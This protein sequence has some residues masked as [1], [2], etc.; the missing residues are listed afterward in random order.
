I[1]EQFLLGILAQVSLSSRCTDENEAVVAVTTLDAMVKCRENHESLLQAGLIE[2]VEELIHSR[3]DAALVITLKLIC[4]LMERGTPDTRSSVFNVI[5]VMKCV[6]ALAHTKDVSQS[7]IS[8]AQSILAWIAFPEEMRIINDARQRLNDEGDGIKR[9]LLQTGIMQKLSQ[10]LKMITKKLESYSPNDQ[11]LDDNEKKEQDKEDDKQIDDKDDKE[12]SNKQTPLNKRKKRRKKKGKLDDQNR[13]KEIIQVSVQCKNLTLGELGLMQKVLQLIDSMVQEN[14][15]VCSEAIRT[16]AAKELLS[17]LRNLPLLEVTW[18]HSMTVLRLVESCGPENAPRLF[19]M[20]YGQGIIQI[21]PHKNRM[22]VREMSAALTVLITQGIAMLPAN[23]HPFKSVYVRDGI[24]DALFKECVQ[25]HWSCKK[26]FSMFSIQGISGVND[27]VSE[28]EKQIV[29]ETIRS[30]GAIAIGCIHNAALLPT[31]I[32]TSVI[33]QLVKTANMNIGSMCQRGL[34]ALASLARCQENHQSLIQG[35]AIEMASQYI[36]QEAVGLRLDMVGFALDLMSVFLDKG[37]E[38]TRQIVVKSIDLHRVKMMAYEKT[39]NAV[40]NS[41]GGQKDKRSTE[42]ADSAQKMLQW[43]MDPDQM[44]AVER[45][46]VAQL[47]EIMNNPDMI[48]LLQEMEQKEMEKR[49]M[50]GF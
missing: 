35:G 17:L 24:I 31:S 33:A 37:S 45:E 6:T 25:R 30:N 36:N 19:T 10:Y 3:K 2:L 4:S 11:Q 20:G 41:N 23:K 27:D 47:N 32:A 18:Q 49:G 21:L 40:K 15:V 29:E 39:S 43:I 26:S 1:P 34:A 50:K 7:I 44:R 48:M 13:D 42:N 28:D 38:Q 9:D 8:D 46:T 14:M 5:S 22:V 12:E 16:G